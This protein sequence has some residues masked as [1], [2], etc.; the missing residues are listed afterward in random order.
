MLARAKDRL[1]DNSVAYLVCNGSYLP[2]PPGTFD[3]VFHFGGINEFSE[4][5][6]AIAEMGRVTKAGGIVVFGDESVPPWQRERTF[7][8]V[9]VAANKLYRHEPP[10]GALPEHARDVSIRWVLGGA[11][12]LI[13]FT[14]GAGAPPIDLDLPIPGKRDSLRSRY[15]AA[16]PND[17]L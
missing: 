11:F 13:R 6:R 14:V 10:L 4:K 1:G 8:K 2:F 16:Y 9:L 15:N 12:Y 7:G 3:R 17:P 5:E